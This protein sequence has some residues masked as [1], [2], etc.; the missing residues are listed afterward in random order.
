MDSAHVGYSKPEAIERLIV[1][2]NAGKQ[3]G[4]VIDE[5]D[6]YDMLGTEP[7]TVTAVSEST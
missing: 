3:S 5:M 2:L 6:V 7:S 1:A 4:P